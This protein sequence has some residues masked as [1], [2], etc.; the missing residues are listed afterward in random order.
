MPSR[1]FL[2][3]LAVQERELAEGF[4]QISYYPNRIMPF[5]FFFVPVFCFFLLLQR[6][7]S[8]AMQWDSADRTMD[9][10]VSNGKKMTIPSA[11]YPFEK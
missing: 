3:E 9:P 10:P 11:V 4:S 1:L 5:Q 2:F 7:G 6:E 8:S